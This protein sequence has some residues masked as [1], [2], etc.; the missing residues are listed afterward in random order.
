MGSRSYAVTNCTSSTTFHHTGTAARSIDCRAW[1]A[2]G[3]EEE[4]A[5]PNAQSSKAR[6]SAEGN[7][8]NCSID[9]SELYCDR[10]LTGGAGVQVWQGLED[11]IH[12]GQGNSRL[13]AAV[14][15]GQTRVGR[16]R[17]IEREPVHPVWNE[18]FRIYAAHEVSDVVITVRDDKPIGAT[19]IGRAK[20]P[21]TEVLSRR[22]IDDWY[23]LFTDT[24]EAVKGGEGKVRFCIRFYAAVDDPQWSRGIRD[25]RTRM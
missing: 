16:T 19:T 2:F 10:T 3:P 21:V 24:G 8:L 17:I 25:P 12:L 11:A 18:S 7:R 14:D 15:L 9:C 1:N 13:Y 4:T 22:T 23:D 20:L 6:T 5:L